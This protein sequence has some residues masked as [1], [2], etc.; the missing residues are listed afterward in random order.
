MRL[1]QRQRR[2]SDKRE[3]IGE[4]SGDALI[5]LADFRFLVRN[6][7]AQAVGV[8]SA[9]FRIGKKQRV[10]E[11]MVGSPPFYDRSG[12]PV[13]R[14]KQELSRSRVVSEANSEYSL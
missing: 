14:P 9:S 6:T 7:S 11:T 8:F 2:R 3:V 1:D 12:R 4:I 13:E 10:G 5:G